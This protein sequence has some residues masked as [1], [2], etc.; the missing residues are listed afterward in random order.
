VDA[1]ELRAVG[2]CT[3]GV[4]RLVDWY[5]WSW[6]DLAAALEGQ[7]PGA[8]IAA[9]REL[10]SAR[11]PVRGKRHDDATAAWARLGPPPS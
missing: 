1:R 2:A 10:E 4:G 6:D 5:G 7:G 8:V 9:V 3:D 11:G